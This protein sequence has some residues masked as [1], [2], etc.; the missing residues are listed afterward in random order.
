MTNGYIQTDI[1]G[2]KRGLKFG[3]IAIQQITLDA[4]RLGAVLGSYCKV[5]SR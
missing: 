2:R 1:L 3:M 5:P 4:K